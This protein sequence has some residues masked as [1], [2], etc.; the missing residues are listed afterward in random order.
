MRGCGRDRLGR[1]GPLPWLI[2]FFWTILYLVL[3]G[4]SV[5]I[6]SPWLKQWRGKPRSL[7]DEEIVTQTLSRKP[8]LYRW[9][10]PPAALLAIGIGGAALV[11][12]VQEGIHPTAALGRVPY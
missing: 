7:T 5:Q 11:I 8:W 10:E 9:F 2:N 4:V 12:S 1:G 3:I 6:F